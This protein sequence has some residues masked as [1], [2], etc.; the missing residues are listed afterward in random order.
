MLVCNWIAFMQ[1]VLSQMNHIRTHAYKYTQTCMCVCVCMWYRCAIS[2]RTRISKC[3]IH[4]VT[5]SAM[6]CIQNVIYQLDL[7]EFCLHISFSLNKYV[8]YN[9]YN[10]Y[11]QCAYRFQFLP[12]YLDHSLL[13]VIPSKLPREGRERRGEREKEE[14][15]RLGNLQTIE[16]EMIP[17]EQI[18]LI[19]PILHFSPS[20]QFVEH[21]IPVLIKYT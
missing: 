12:R 8:I 14:G 7:L 11:M 13:C 1:I 19:R 20:R 21:G 15:D 18:P 16:W 3:K 5:L 10:Q 2:T 4:F 6:S 9:I 17:T